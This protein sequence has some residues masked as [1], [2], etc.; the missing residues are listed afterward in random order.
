MLIDISKFAECRPLLSPD[1][2]LS[3]SLWSAY[4]CCLHIFNGLPSLVRKILFEE[5]TSFS[6]VHNSPLKP[7]LPV[8]LP[9]HSG[10]TVQWILSGW[11]SA[12]LSIS[13]FSGFAGDDLKV[14]CNFIFYFLMSINFFRAYLNLTFIL[15]CVYIVCVFVMFTLLQIE[16]QQ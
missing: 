14:L 11:H 16:P 13:C 7:F 12:T 9:C 6:L 4:V 2:E 1:R 15:R 3:L 8:Q 5:S 10:D